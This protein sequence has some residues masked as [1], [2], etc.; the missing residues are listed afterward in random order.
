MGGMLGSLM[1]MKAARLLRGQAGDE[2]NTSAVPT[3]RTTDQDALSSARA[4]M[5]LRRA[6]PATPVVSEEASQ[7]QPLLAASASPPSSSPAAGAPSEQ[8]LRERESRIHALMSA[9]ADGENSS[10]SVPSFRARKAGRLLQAIRVST[11]AAACTVQCL[12]SPHV[13]VI[14]LCGV[15]SLDG[16]GKIDSL[17]EFQLLVTNIRYMVVTQYGID[18]SSEVYTLTHSCSCVETLL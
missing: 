18:V 10:G 16:S 7:Q 8:V 9:V 15:R 3:A 2:E 11:T 4:S 6:T 14:D 13:A 5:L 12:Y 17:T 1:E